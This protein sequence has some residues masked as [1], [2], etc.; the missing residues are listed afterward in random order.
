VPLHTSSGYTPTY[1]SGDF[2]HIRLSRSGL[3]CFA[4]DPIGT[5]LRQQE[6]R[7]FFDRHPDWSLLGKMVMDARHAVDA[8]SQHPQVGR[9]V[10]AGY[11]MG[12]LV[13]LLTASS[14]ERVAGVASIAGFTPWRTD[15]AQKHTGGLY[16]YSH[17]NGWLPRLGQFIGREQ[18]V[19]VDLD[20][21]LASIAPRPA[22]VVAPQHDRHADSA[23]VSLAVSNAR[24]AYTERS[25]SD[26]LSFISPDDYNRLTDERQD[27]VIHW[28]RT[29]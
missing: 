3:I 1:R 12:G 11:G 28:A 26:K 19:P 7:E 13:A 29:I 22:L 24:A 18:D 23:D 6:R 25:A 21:I 10:V 4:F 15:S 5:A 17:L 16:R 2:F 8:L 20:E 27:E 9:I 14:D